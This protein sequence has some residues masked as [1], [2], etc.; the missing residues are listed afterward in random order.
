MCEQ[1][2][3]RR[4]RHILK[5]EVSSGA[6]CQSVADVR[7]LNVLII[8]APNPLYQPLIPSFA[9]MRSRTCSI[10]LFMCV[11]FFPSE[12]VV[13]NAWIRVFALWSD[14]GLLSKLNTLLHI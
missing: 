4:S 11:I 3:R 12:D 9:Y 2:S 1:G 10:P 8:V 6:K 13:G 5:T 7:I 14:Q